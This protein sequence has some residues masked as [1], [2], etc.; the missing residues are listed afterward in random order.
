MSID[1]ALTT[2]AVSSLAPTE[3]SGHW[4]HQC[5]EM[6]P[7]RKYPTEITVSSLAPT[8]E[9]GHWYHQCLEMQTMSAQHVQVGGPLLLV[10]LAMIVISCRGELQIH[11]QNIVRPKIGERGG[12]L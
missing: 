10:S 3:K 6:Q 1:F 8:E 2:T 11:F 9:S 12:K 5:L 4:Y 7:C